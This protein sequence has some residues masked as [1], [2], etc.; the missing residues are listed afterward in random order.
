[1]ILPPLITG[2]EIV[3]EITAFLG[4]RG[5]KKLQ[6]YYGP[7][8]VHRLP[9]PELGEQAGGHPAKESLVPEGRA[10]DTPPQTWSRGKREGLLNPG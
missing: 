3:R 5:T 9:G 6:N 2:F 7:D 8:L 10:S 4:V 1:M